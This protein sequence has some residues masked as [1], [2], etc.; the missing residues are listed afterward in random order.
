MKDYNNQSELVASSEPQVG[1]ELDTLL[2]QCAEQGEAISILGERLSGALRDRV[3]HDET[4]LVDAQE[5]LVPIADTIRRARRS[6]DENTILIK[7]MI[8]RL[9][10]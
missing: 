5:E 1:R 2:K 10:I 8:D 6:L 9:E 7:E 4:K 3:V